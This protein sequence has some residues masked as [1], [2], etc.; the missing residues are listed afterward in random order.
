M[1]FPQQ[2]RSDLAAAEAESKRKQLGERRVLSS[3]LSTTDTAG[4]SSGVVARFRGWL[5]RALAR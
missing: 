2:S 1:S 3:N 4:P 5:R